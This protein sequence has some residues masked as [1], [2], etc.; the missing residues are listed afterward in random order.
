MSDLQ[1]TEK[2]ELNQLKKENLELKNVI[3]DIENKSNNLKGENR[4]LRQLINDKEQL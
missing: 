3:K 4:V 1:K 2:N